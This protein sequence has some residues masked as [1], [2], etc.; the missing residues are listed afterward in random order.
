[1]VG[2]DRNE[3]WFEG[4]EVRLTNWNREAF[5]QGVVCLARHNHGDR[6]TAEGFNSGE[7]FVGKVRGDARRVNQ[8][9]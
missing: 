1:M 2:A 7:E 6:S 8:I 3:V 4:G 5:T 9:G